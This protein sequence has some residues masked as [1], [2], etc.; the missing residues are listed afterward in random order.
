M[1]GNLQSRPV[2]FLHQDDVAATLSRYLPAVPSKGFD[3][4]PAAKL[5]QG[6]GHQTATSTCFVSM[7]RG[8]PPS[9]RTSKQSSMASRMFFRALVLLSPW[10]TQPGIAGHS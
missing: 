9:A 6:P 8:R 2:P 7:V 3:D 10:L 5:R 1:I 4:G